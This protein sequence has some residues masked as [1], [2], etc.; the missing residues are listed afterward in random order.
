MQNNLEWLSGY[1]FHKGHLYS[2]ESDRVI[3]E[4]IEPFVKKCFE[5]EWI[6]NYFFIRYS[7]DGA[8]IRIRFFGESEKLQNI[9]K[10][11]FEQFIKLN[12]PE[13]LKVDSPDYSVLK[14]VEYEP[15]IERYGGEYAIK[16][17]EECFHYS[18]DFAIQML[19][20][21]ENGNN[22]QRLGKG[23]IATNIIIYAFAQNTE[24]G[25][26]LSDSYHNGYLFRIAEQEDVKN[27]VLEM[28]NDGFEKQ[29]DTLIEFVNTLWEVLEIE[30]ELPESL[31]EF[32]NNI[33]QIRKKL[34]ALNEEG[35]LIPN[36]PELTIEQKLLYVVPSYIHMMN[37]RLGISIPE[38]SY[39]T[40]LISKALK[41]SATKGELVND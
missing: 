3:L 15:E 38:E 34:T 21:V 11:E 6:K 2:Y 8:H 9:V 23:L 27:N 7:V 4:V 18:S 22:S 40:F 5:N 36:K 14:W 26:S 31:E 33:L 35:K 19:H 32:Y 20:D 28:F 25:L 17:A 13:D 1:V 12:F 29:S 39:L 37:N 10:P 24:L 30:S 41:S 16:I